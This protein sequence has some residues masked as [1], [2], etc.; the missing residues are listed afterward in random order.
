MSATIQLRDNLPLTFTPR[1]NYQW[2]VNNVVGIKQGMILLP[3]T[4]GVANTVVSSYED[5][6]TLFEG[7]EQE[8]T[9]VNNSAEAI[10]TKNKLPTVTN[11]VITGQEGNIV[12][13]NQQPFAFAGD[14]LRIGGYGEDIIKSATGY[15]IKFSNLK[16]KLDEITTTTTAAVYDSTSVPITSRNGILDNV[17]EVSGIGIDA[18]AINPTASSGAGAVSGSG[19]IVLSAAQNLESGTTLTFANAGQKATI[20][21]EIEILK[22]GTSTSIIYFDMEKPLTSA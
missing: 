11:G 8:Y 14:N 9:I 12:F 20:T 6:T 18:S 1:K 10:N 17:S 2:P 16:I 13:N 4:N 7:T 19:T 22:V 15:D 3:S 5:T 21:G